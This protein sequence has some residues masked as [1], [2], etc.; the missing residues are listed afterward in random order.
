MVCTF[1]LPISGGSSLH[2]TSDEVLLCVLGTAR[3]LKKTLSVIRFIS[4]VV[5]WFVS[6]SE[7]GVLK[8]MSVQH[9]FRLKPSA[10]DLFVHEDS[11][12][13]EQ[14]LAFTNMPMDL[15]LPWHT[16]VFTFKPI[17]VKSRMNNSDMEL[18]FLILY[19]LFFPNL[20]VFSINHYANFSRQ[21]TFNGRL[22]LA[23]Y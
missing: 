22:A 12:M 10:W 9:G 3:I 18:I 1:W 4:E 11:P 13:V 5:N 17:L 2:M 23:N 15:R 19:S 20:T 14:D 6:C 7:P 8:L 16:W 21:R